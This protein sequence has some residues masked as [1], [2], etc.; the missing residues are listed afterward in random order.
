MKSWNSF[1]IA[2]NRKVEISRWRNNEIFVRV[3]SKVLR[4]IHTDTNINTWRFSLMN[5]INTEIYIV[6]E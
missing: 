4:L 6:K 2:A 1:D 5:H 3:G